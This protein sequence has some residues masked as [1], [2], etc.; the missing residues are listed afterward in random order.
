MITIIA[1]TNRPNSDTFAVAKYYQEQLSQLVEEPVNLLS[2]TELPKDMFNPAMYTAEGQSRQLMDLQDLVMIPAQR[3]V[4][5]SPEY[6]GSFP[7][8]LKFFLD[9]CSIREIGPTYRGK[10]A[11]LVGVASG[12]AGNLRGMEHLTGILNYLGIAVLPLKLP[13]SQIGKLRDENGQLT[14]QATREAIGDQLQKFLA[15]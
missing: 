6:N 9:A 2:L 3:F 11:V 8:I 4:F 5:V 14:D 12:R 1:G 7:G 15:F 10:K 13:I